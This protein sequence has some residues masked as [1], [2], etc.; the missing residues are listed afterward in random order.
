MERHTL[1]DIVPALRWHAEDVMHWKAGIALSFMLA[2]SPTVAATPSW[3]SA[4]T[5]NSSERTICADENLGRLDLQLNE[6]YRE[7]L[8]VAPDLDQRDWLVERNRCGRRLT[9]LEDAYRSRITELWAVA[10]GWPARAGD[11]ALRQGAGQAPDQVQVPETSEGALPPS[12]ATLGGLL[13]LRMAQGL[14]EMMPRS[15]CNAA[16]LNP[17]ERTICGHR[18]LSR[19]DALLELVYGRAAARSED[20][21]QVDWLRLE[22]DACGTDH[23]CIAQAYAARIGQLHGSRVDIDE[24]ESDAAIP[25]GHYPPPGTCR[26]WHL[27]RPPGQQPPPTSCNVRVPAGA[28]LIRG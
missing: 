1:P 2:A 16:R 8:H 7:A 4:T 21:A 19:L 27:D 17:T 18:D 26:V 23:L 5:L 25:P 20:R 3:C 6:A 22:R 10:A 24:R 13:S 28:V 12:G 9:C 11:D 15:W 14:D